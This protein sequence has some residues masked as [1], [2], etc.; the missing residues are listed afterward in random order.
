MAGNNGSR[1]KRRRIFQL[2]RRIKRTIYVGVAGLIFI[3]IAAIF[4][5]GKKTKE[6][7]EKKADVAISQELAEENKKHETIQK[8]LGEDK[9]G[10]R[11]GV[12]YRKYP[13]VEKILLNREDYPD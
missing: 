2:R 3:I 4:C 9:Y 11:L 5:G 13:K 7:K 12:L 6:T 8:A 10:D 1:A